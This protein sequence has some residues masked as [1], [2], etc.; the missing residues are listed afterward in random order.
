MGGDLKGLIETELPWMFWMWCMAHRLELAIKKTS[1]DLVDGMLLNLY[2]LYA[3]SPKGLASKG[4][5]Q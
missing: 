5:Y 2:T 1:F 4:G 3:K